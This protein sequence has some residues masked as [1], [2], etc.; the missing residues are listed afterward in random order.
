MV[1][2]MEETGKVEL[3]VRWAD[4]MMLAKLARLTKS[5]EARRLT[6]SFLRLIFMN[7]T[8]TQANLWSFQGYLF[9]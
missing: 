6:A 2:E 7:T 1:E 3:E 8:Y 9:L 5:G 4:L